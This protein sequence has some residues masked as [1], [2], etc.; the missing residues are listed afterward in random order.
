M[1]LLWIILLSVS[2]SA[3]VDAQSRDDRDAATEALAA[4]RDGDWAG[5]KARAANHAPAISKIVLWNRLSA[6]LGTFSEVE[7]FLRDDADWPG[8]AVIRRRNEDNV[9]ADRAADFFA[10]HS[11]QT[12]VGVLAYAKATR[13]T[14]PKQADAQLVAAWTSLR[15]PLETER[16]FL[17]NHGALLK[18]HHPARIDML[19]WKNQRNEARR[20]LPFVSDDQVALAEARIALQVRAGDVDTKLKAVQKKLLRHGGLVHDRFEWRMRKGLHQ[21][22]LELLVAHSLSAKALGNPEGWSN[23]RRSIARDLMRDDQNTLAYQVASTHFL[24]SG[25]NYADLEW[26]SGYIAL[27]KLNE[28]AKALK[29]LTAFEAAVKTPISKG[30]AFY[31]LGRTHE[32]LGDT[33]AAKAAYAKG[34]DHQTSF[35]GL[36]AAEKANLSLDPALVGLDTPWEAAPFT[37]RSVFQAAALFVSTGEDALAERFLTHLTDI[38]PAEEL[39]ALGAFAVAKKRPHIAVMIGKRAARRGIVIPQAYFPVHPMAEMELPVST[40]IALAIARRESEFDPVVISSA[41]ARGLMQLMPGT[42]KAVARDKGLAYRKARL[43]GDWHYNA[44]LGSAYLAELRSDFGNSPVMISAGYNAG[45]GR[46][47]SWMD[48]FGDPR[49]GEIDII[50]WIEHIPFRETRNYVMR[51]TESLPIYRAR[52]T[53]VAGPLNFMNELVGELPLQR[54]NARPATLGQKEASLSVAPATE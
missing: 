28:P 4:I 35:Y 49:K 21:S 51:V 52:L 27:R 54:P 10:V 39:P 6:G 29:H 25:S 43:L 24:T 33:D 9:P 48:R 7:A 8:L 23:R 13:A 18:P 37:D 20:M 50:D 16:L 14:D 31:W 1:R 15:M 12:G 36:L 19:L 44:K 2:F 47:R 26:L 34:A 22:A 41:G 32:A 17:R 3:S 42:A 30:R 11:P 38:L 40:E 5:A 46:P 53:G 45:P